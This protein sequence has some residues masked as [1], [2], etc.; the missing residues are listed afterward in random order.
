MGTVTARRTDTGGWTAVAATNAALDLTGIR[1]DAADGGLRGEV[2]STHPAPLRVTLSSTT[3]EELATSEL[4]TTADSGPTP[5]VLD[6]D[7]V[8]EA[9][10]GQPVLLRVVAGDRPGQVGVDGVGPAAFASVVLPGWAGDGAEDGTATTT[11]SATTGP[12]STTEAGSGGATASAA[13]PVEGGAGRAPGEGILW[14]A[15][16]ADWGETVADAGEAFAWAALGYPDAL[17]VLPTGEAGPDDAWTEVGIQLS[18]EGGMLP[19][20]IGREG[21]EWVV[22]GVG[23]GT[24]GVHRD[25]GV[26]T[27]VA[28][29]VPEGL[30][31]RAE[32]VHATVVRPDGSWSR[33]DTTAVGDRLLGAAGAIL[34]LR[35]DAGTLIGAVGG[36][37]GD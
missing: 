36:P 32:Q 25:E 9:T 6:L 7:E 18:G 11:P 33:Y 26:E 31:D 17:V 14:R 27:L 35:D 29:G 13:M 1:Y 30:L 2:R 37:L 4:T 12:P 21:D 10:D 24:V 3:G 16:V 22:H 5:S 8:L 28:T 19:V 20:R 34:L 15:S 23:E